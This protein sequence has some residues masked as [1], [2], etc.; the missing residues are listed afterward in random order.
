[1]EHNK[2]SHHRSLNKLTNISRRISRYNYNQI[3]HKSY[4][5]QKEIDDD[6]DSE[7]Q[8]YQTLDKYFKET[9]TNDKIYFPK[10]I[11]SNIY[12]SKQFL[13]LE[14]LCYKFI[15]PIKL[16]INLIPP[17]HF[18]ISE[19]TSLD[20]HHQNQTEKILKSYF[21]FDS[22]GKIIIAI[23]DRLIMLY[24]SL[25]YNSFW[26]HLNFQLSS[27]KLLIIY[28]TENNNGTYLKILV[29]LFSFKKITFQQ[30][31][32]NQDKKNEIIKG[33][34]SLTCHLINFYYIK[35]FLDR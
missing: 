29:K 24:N 15:N 17:Y 1:M 27:P 34:K 3:Q 33:I 10:F 9:N 13:I 30:N 22:Q 25:K 12:N 31:Q 8:F 2:R 5:Y 16:E 21:E 23:I 28:E 7:L 18:Y 6:D 20:N 26:N 19:E 4:Y 35:F 32:Q 14:N 11:R